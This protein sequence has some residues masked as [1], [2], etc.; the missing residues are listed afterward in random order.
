MK[1]VNELLTHGI[2]LDLLIVVCTY[3]TW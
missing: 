3:N 1:T 2:M